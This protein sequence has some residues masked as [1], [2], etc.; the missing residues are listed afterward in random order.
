MTKV[1]LLILFVSS[2]FAQN[3]SLGP[4]RQTS[5]PD[6]C[7][8]PAGS[9]PPSLPAR[10]LAGQG[11]VRFPITTQNPQAQQFFEQGVAQMHSFWAT[12]AERS[13]LQ[14]AQF[15]PQ[16][17][18]PYWGIAMSAAGDY[19]PRFQLDDSR[20]RKKKLEGGEARSI[21]AAR[22]ALQL[23]T[24]PGKT[25]A[26]ERLYIQAIAAR[27]DPKV[28]D[29][30]QAYVKA[31]RALLAQY[32]QEI[33]AKAYL[34]LHLMRGFTLP[35][36]K[37]RADSME[38]VA[39]LKELLVRAP[40]HPGVHHY[41]IHGF[42]G[43]TFAREAWPSCRR[44]SE[45]VPNIPH[46]L[47]MPGHIY[48]QTGK[49]KEAVD[50]FSAAAENELGYIRADSLYG[51]G[52]HGHNVHFL[53]SAY[54]FQDNYQK[55]IAASRSLMEFKENPREAAEVDNHYTLYRRGWF[56]LLFTLVQFKKWDE[57]L[58]GKTLPLYEKPWESAWRHWAMGLSYAA[59]G[60]A[61]AAKAEAKGFRTAVHDLEVK[62]KR[63]APGPLRVASQELDGHIALASNKV[64]K[65]LAILHRAARQER[66]LRYSEPPSYPRPVLPVLAEAAL[67]SG[68][69][70]L[71]E[72]AFREA[73]DQYP[74]SFRALQG[75]QQALQQ[76]NG[77]H[78]AAAH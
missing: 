52:H 36:R 12:E 29:P 61:S 49:W 45:L 5:S 19:R 23:S 1:F 13:F 62:T 48:A 42:E 15:D 53:I 30:D 6:L 16:A 26:L 34:A 32:P 41:V 17:P 64:D 9:V 60:Q 2:G 76:T 71:A 40:D 14:A 31:L 58:D 72:S 38:A 35:Q 37:P 51:L 20:P 8:P 10:L 24:I 46:A 33:E 75:L 56:S 21:E 77:K 47:H 50:A 73:L 11:T 7:V 25:T 4:P 27:R 44:Y 78:D 57:I 67:K 59:K 69:P 43:S 55:A 22:K 18:M 70:Q 39:L 74:E 66:A 54:S 28:K 68:R 65:A 63:P 3:T